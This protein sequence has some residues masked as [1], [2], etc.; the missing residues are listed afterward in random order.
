MRP[1]VLECIT[2]C[3]C[4]I[5]RVFRL[6]TQLTAAKYYLLTYLLIRLRRRKSPSVFTQTTICCCLCDISDH[7][8]PHES[9]V[10]RFNTS[11]IMFAVIM[12]AAKFTVQ[13]QC[14]FS[15]FSAILIT[16]M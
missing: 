14:M 6:I 9:L 4:E 5:I 12:N 13:K 11:Q 7:F 3:C 10:E 1:R 16:L 15:I 8:L 2:K